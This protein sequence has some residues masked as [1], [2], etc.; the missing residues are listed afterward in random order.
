MKFNYHNKKFEIISNSEN[1]E[2]STDLTFHYIQAGNI[3][4]CNYS[5]LNIKHGHIL[6]LVEDDGTI[7]IHYHQIN[8]KDELKT[9]V[10]TSKPETLAN[11]KIRIH[12]KW[13]WTT[14][15]KTEGFTTLE[16]VEA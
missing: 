8:Q 2:I 4:T 10:C 16:E 13:R 5:D 9:G 11:G 1:G 14:G 7:H 3:L 6:G 15:D 12:E